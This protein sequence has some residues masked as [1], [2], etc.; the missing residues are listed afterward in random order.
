MGKKV[1]YSFVINLYMLWST[2]I[3]FK[4]LLNIFLGV[5]KNDNCKIDFR[6]KINKRFMYN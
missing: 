5:F 4:T 3:Q 1:P 2:S 6:K